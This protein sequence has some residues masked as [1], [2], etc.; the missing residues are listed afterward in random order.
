MC[1]QKDMR[2]WGKVQVVT[3]SGERVEVDADELMGSLGKEVGWGMHH[4]YRHV[5]MYNTSVFV[6]YS[7]H[8]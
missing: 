5:H 3:S 1:I 8:Q 2:V 6:I 7:I 4:V